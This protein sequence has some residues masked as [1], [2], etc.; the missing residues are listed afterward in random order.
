MPA[1]KTNNI[2]NFT[3]KLG[4]V[5]LAT[6]TIFYFGANK[7]YAREIEEFYDS[8]SSVQGCSSTDTCVSQDG[9][10]PGTCYTT[11]SVND[12]GGCGKACNNASAKLWSRYDPY[13]RFDKTDDIGNEKCSWV[14]VLGGQSYSTADKCIGAETGLRWGNCDGSYGGIYKTCCQR[15][16]PIFPVTV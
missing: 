4:V 11:G 3:F 7:L 12:S 16:A 9:A 5:V 1:K 14:Y 15:S 10:S 13:C 8:S 2:I 6:F